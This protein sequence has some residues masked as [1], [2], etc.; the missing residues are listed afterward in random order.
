M[1]TPVCEMLGC[2][3]PIVAFTHCRDVVAA[4][5]KA[6]GFGVLGAAG[7]TPEQLDIDMGWI[8]DEVGG[9]PFGVDIIVP[10]KY[11]GKSEGE[12]SVKDLKAMIPPAH[13]DFLDDMMERYD[14]PPLPADDKPGAIAGDAEPP[15]TY[16]QAVPLMDV[17]FSYPIRLAVNALGPPPPDM[18]Q[19]AHDNDVLVGALAGKKVHAERHVA[20]GVDIVIAQG[21]EAGGHTGDIATMVLV[22]EVVDAIAP[23]PVLAAGGI[24]NG[25]QVAAA[26]ALGAQGVWCGSVWL[27]TQEAET[28]PVVKDK[29]LA[30]GS[31]DTLR[32]RSRTGKPARQLRSAWTD[33]WEGENSPGTLPMPLQPM[34]IGAA[35]RRIDRAAMNPSNKGAVELANYFVGQVV[36]QLNE[37]ISATRVVEEMIS[38]Y[39]DVMERFEQLNA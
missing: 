31:S 33:E 7:H 37:S 2:D 15:M 26:L 13:R 32:S 34:L 18:I 6:G 24:G 4:V 8:Q 9:R 30:A 35:S 1:K 3:V 11:E 23:V 28:H 27:T 17:A 14:V 25:R 39:L 29:F 22:P 36:G 38:E 5:T 12:L 10:A 20:A 21:H 16:A 19:R